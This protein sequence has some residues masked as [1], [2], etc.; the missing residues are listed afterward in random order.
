MPIM[1]YS[2]QFAMRIFVQEVTRRT[3]AVQTWGLRGGPAEDEQQ[4]GSGSLHL[5]EWRVRPVT[6]QDYRYRT[7]LALMGS[8]NISA[9]PI[10][11]LAC[12]I[13]NQIQI[14]TLLSTGIFTR[15]RS[16]EKKNTHPT[17]SGCPFN[18][19]RAPTK[20]NAKAPRRFRSTKT[21]VTT[22]FS[23]ELIITVTSSID[24]HAKSCFYHS[25]VKSSIAYE[26]RTQS[27]QTLVQV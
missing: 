17:P 1:C 22:T 20:T 21:P 13:S 15:V 7:V 9:E 8:A 19:P 23:R 4:K 11:H 24:T 12:T 6:C 14:T 26:L 27:K 16:P 3:L 2:D 18:S 10:L 25:Q 5:T